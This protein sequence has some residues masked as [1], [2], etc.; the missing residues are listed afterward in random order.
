MAK[1]AI[2]LGTMA[3]A[4]VFVLASCA[5]EDEESEMETGMEHEGMDH[6]DMVHDDSGTIPEGLTE[7]QNPTYVPGDPVIIE[8]G[9]MEGMEGASAVIVG[10]FDTTAYEV[11]YDPVIGGERVENH[12]WVIQEE[13]EGAGGELFDS[14]TQVILDA[15]HMEGMRGA[16]AT[17]EDSETS[18]VYMIDYMPTNGG[19]QV[20]NHKWVIESELSQE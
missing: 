13:I 11:S 8:N 12:K 4:S 10:A 18:T 14:G 5:N 7:A 15:E 9:H 3:I 6:G 2:L 19:E 17:I 16:S 20:V 1:K